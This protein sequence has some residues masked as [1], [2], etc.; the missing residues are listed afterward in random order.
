MPPAL[1]CGWQRW[2]GTASSSL[3]LGTAPRC[4]LARPSP[5]CS[6]LRCGCAPHPGD[7]VGCPWLS[8]QSQRP[9][10]E[11]GGHWASSRGAGALGWPPGG[12]STVVQ[13]R[14][15]VRERGV[16]SRG[17]LGITAWWHCGCPWVFP[18]SRL[19]ADRLPPRCSC[20]RPARH[21]ARKQSGWARAR[22][23]WCLHP[24]LSVVVVQTGPAQAQ[25]WR[26][27]RVCPHRARAS[28]RWDRR[29]SWQGTSRA[30]LQ[31]RGVVFSWQRLAGSSE[32]V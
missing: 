2:R 31:K 23:T 17:L 24:V 20:P 27:D 4:R 18:V 32:G 28:G 19:H 16:D 10:G 7:A 12:V 11:R 29:R 3:A 15:E 9:A 1:G 25:S 22:L 8:P 14:D 6:A 5:L 21:P 30:G 13:H 26:W